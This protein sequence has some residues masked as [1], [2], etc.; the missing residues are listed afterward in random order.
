VTDHRT[1]RR[2]EAEQRRVTGR[3]SIQADVV[4]GATGSKGSIAGSKREMR[5][6]G[7]IRR[8]TGKKAYRE[9]MM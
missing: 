3:Y 1:V 5:E 7:R 6:R 4:I 2:H 8:V 9:E